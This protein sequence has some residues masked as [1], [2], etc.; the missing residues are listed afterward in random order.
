MTECTTLGAAYMA[1]ME[2]GTWRDEKD[3]AASW[4]PKH[5]VEPR[6]GDNPRSA[7]RDRWL[8]ARDR[9]RQTI[10]EL[11]AVQFWDT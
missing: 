8:A 6:L 7:V 9:A 2:L 1:G 4:R 5:V 11:S 3:V 10:P